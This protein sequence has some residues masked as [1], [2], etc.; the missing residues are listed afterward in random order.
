MSIGEILDSINK[1]R[2][3]IL[4]TGNIYTREAARWV[5]EHIDAKFTSVD[6]DSTLQMATHKEL[7]CDGT[8]RYCT[9]LT[10]DHVKHLNEQSW[11]DICLLNPSDLQTG[12]MEFS[13]AVSTGASIIVMNDFQARSALAIKKAKAL[14]WE[15]S[16]QGMMNVLRRPE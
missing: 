16:S 15:Y 7:E 10:K 4:E 9:F 13:L 5:R 6:I 2:L 8:A 12:L 3:V 1:P 14:G 11:V